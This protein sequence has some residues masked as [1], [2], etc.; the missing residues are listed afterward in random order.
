M[1]FWKRR[2]SNFLFL[3][4]FYNVC[5]IY[6]WRIWGPFSIFFQNSY[7]HI[8]TNDWSICIEL[9]QKSRFCPMGLQLAVLTHFKALKPIFRFSE[10]KIDWLKSANKKDDSDDSNLLAGGELC[11]K[12][13]H[14]LAIL[15]DK[16]YEGLA[17]KIRI[18]IPKK[19]PK[20]GF[21]SSAEKNTKCSHF[22]WQSPGWELFWTNLLM[23]IIFAEVEME[24]AKI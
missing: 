22:A 19:K 14:S 6:N 7:G 21:L 17:E 2:K 20:D 3:M 1:V 13:P 16:S 18:T 11:E 24:W 8:S 15:T 4:V 10:K 5:A 12:F 9:K 23:W